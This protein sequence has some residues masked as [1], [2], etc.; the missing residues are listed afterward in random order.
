MNVHGFAPIRHARIKETRACIRKLEFY[1]LNAIVSAVADVVGGLF[2]ASKR[3]KLK[4]ALFSV[5]QGRK[6]G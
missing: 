4:L 3:E 6:M 2:I 5:L 1:S